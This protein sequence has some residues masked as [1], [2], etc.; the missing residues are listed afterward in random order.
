MSIVGY[1]KDY[2]YIIT[3]RTDDYTSVSKVVINPETALYKTQHYEILK[4]EDIFDN[5]VDETKFRIKK[6]AFFYIKKDLALFDRFIEYK[7]YQLFPLGY[8][9]IHR[10]Y[11]ENG[12]IY[13]EFYHING[14]IDGEYRTFYNNGNP[15]I[16]CDYVN[17]QKLGRD[18]EYKING[19]LY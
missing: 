5:D 16:I 1:F 14:V 3:I 17:G 19:E 2:N 12:N 9:G 8:S 11:H 6:T 10:E 15:Q 4:M 18:I 13:R 7:E